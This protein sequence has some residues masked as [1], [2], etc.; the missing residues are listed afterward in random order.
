[1]KSKIPVQL[2]QKYEIK[3]T[4]M[5]QS[6]EGVG[7]FENFTVF[8]PYALP[9]ETVEA[10]IT[11]VKKNY[12][13]GEIVSILEKTS[14][15]I[16]PICKIYDDCGACQL[17]HYSYEAQLNA[18]KQKVI[19]MM[20]H[21]AIKKDIIIHP[22]MPSVHEWH[23]RNK[24][25]FPIGR[26]KKEGIIVG[27]YAHS[28]HNIINTENC[29]IQKHTNNVI[30]NAVREMATKFKLSVYDE[31][32]HYGLLRHVVG[33]TNR[34]ETE[35]M[36]VLVTAQP[37][38][39]RVREIVNFLR[40]KI[41]NL[42]SVVQNINTGRNN[43]IMGKECKILWG[44]SHITDRL[45]NLKFKIS[46]LSFFQVN[47]EQAEKLYECALK[48]A[49]L[50][51]KETVIDGYC[52]T[53]TI[54]LFLAQKAKK[55]Y[56][57]EIVP[58][59]ICDAIANARDNNIRNAEFLTGDAA[60]LMPQLYRKGLRP[61]VIVTDPPRA[62]CAPEVLKTFAA[63]R[64]KR[65]VYVSCNPASLARDIGILDELGYK[66]TEIQPVDMFPQTGHVESV[67]LLVKK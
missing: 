2:G 56:G 43:I 64:P 13:T 48:Y 45:G 62:G 23:Y 39:P 6:G 21:I 50:T 8:I 24:M 57:M 5:G 38:I 17:Q 59:A 33:R 40:S 3:I 30:A 12:A 51:G 58:E 60:K 1:M 46:A 66:A 20:E 44:A 9:G 61:D 31:K 37:K 18:K 28:S 65:I 54:S 14:D 26:S 19:D 47:T 27:C 34:D 55:V 63:M 53:G 41:P 52:G 11:L 67:C 25:Q 29:H 7:R 10:K 42:T 32:T 16:K 4:G 36:V 35:C 15:R 22:T 49:N